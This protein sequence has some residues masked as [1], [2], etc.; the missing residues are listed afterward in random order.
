MR[1]EDVDFH[2]SHADEAWHILVATYETLF[3]P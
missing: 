1:D 2:N 3:A